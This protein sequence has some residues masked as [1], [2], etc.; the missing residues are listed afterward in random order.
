MASGQLPD[1]QYTIESML[2]RQKVLEVEGEKANDG[3][4]VDLWQ[5]KGE[6]HQRWQLTRVVE[7]SG[8]VFYTI[9][10]PNSPMVMEAP[11]PWRQG[12]PVFM[13]NYDE[14]EDKRHRQW[15]LV[16][17]FGKEDVYKIENRRSGFV[18]DVKDGIAGTEQ[19]KQYASWDA[20]DDRQHWRL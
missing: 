5:D 16:P 15:K 17:V 9:G 4:A 2:L 19:I 10:H 12:D 18:I 6:P 3:T 7:D 1:G 14:G 13:R 20:P 11:G 8:D